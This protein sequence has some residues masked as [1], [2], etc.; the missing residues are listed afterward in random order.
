MSLKI[1]QSPDLKI[2]GVISD[3][4]FK[5]GDLIES[6]Y[7]ILIPRMQEQ[8]INQTVLEQY[9]FEW[10]DKYIAIVLGLGSLYNHSDNPSCVI[11]LDYKKKLINFYALK[12]INPGDELT[13]DYEYSD[14]EKHLLNFNRNLD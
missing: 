12:N 8:Y 10:T 11:R 5:K 4:K 2:R 1:G 3:K 6:C 7:L 13:H 9:Y 14:N